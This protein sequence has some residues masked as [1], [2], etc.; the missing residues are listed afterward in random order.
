MKSKIVL[1]FLL[2]LILLSCSGEDPETNKSDIYQ[3]RA[4]GMLSTSE[5]TVGK[6]LRV[7]D[8]GDW[9]DW[10]ERKILISCKAK[11]KAGINL[12]KIADSDITVNGNKIEIK[13]P[14][15]E[16]ISF[17]MDPDQVK[18]EMMDVTGLRASFSQDDKHKILKLGEQSIK[19]DMYQLDI[20]KDA[21]ANAVAF[22]KDFYETLGYEE[23]IIH[24]TTK[25]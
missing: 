2:A 18:T 8:K 3:V 9:Y 19:K 4:I 22:L 14:P 1:P 12:K 15:P 11:I 5:Y 21:Q 13:L 7:N 25:D 17:E 24:V 23:V 20:L 16:I 6:I 10:G